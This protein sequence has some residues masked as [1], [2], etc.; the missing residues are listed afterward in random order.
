M[1]KFSFFLKRLVRMDWKAMW[2]TAGMLR[3]PSG[4]S[5]LWLLADMLRCALKY[6]AG[7][8]DYKIAQMYRLNDA[9]RKTQITRG[10]S[11]QI[12]RRMND[13]A[14]WYL[15]DDKATFNELFKE[16]VGRG[17]MKLSPDTDPEAFKAFLAA[18][19]DIIAKPLEG[20]SGVGIARYTQ[21]DWQGREDD[22]LKELLD[23]QI[24]I[25]EERVI[26]H[27]KLMALCPTSVNT[28]RIATLLG[29]KK[30]GIVYAFLRIGNG[31]VMDNVDCGG[32][33]APINLDTGVISGVGANKAGE[34]FEFHPMTGKRIPGTQ[35]P[36]WEEVKAMCLKAM[37]VVPQVRFVAWDVAITPDGPVFIEGNS[38]PSHA[39][40]QF[41]AHFPDGIG[42]LPRFEAFIDL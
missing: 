13:K 35:I 2:K 22:F 7:Y 9:Q 14:Y 4:K 33:A 16:E 39:I 32:M 3:K 37:H 31:K 18:H 5:R 28:I 42:I 17:W 38:F 36:Y 12:V 20:S 24:G 26:Q 27:P 11:N 40:P 30:Q 6:N 34:V 1:S 10:L 19:P 29:D 21:D 41:A 15:F 8:V 25:I 23:G